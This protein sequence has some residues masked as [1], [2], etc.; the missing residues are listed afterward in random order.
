MSPK[1]SSQ[2]RAAAP[3][4]SSLAAQLPDPPLD[5]LVF[6]TTV[7]QKRFWSL[8]ALQPGNPALNMPLAARL[9]GQVDRRAVQLAFD[10]IARRH[11]VLRCRFE[12]EGDE[13]VQVVLPPRPVEVHWID[14]TSIPA[15]AVAARIEAVQFE[16]GSRSFDLARGPFLRGAVA[17]LDP[18]EH[19]LMLTMHHIVS[20]GWSNGILL[21]EFAG[22]Y[23]RVL[24]GESP[25]FEDLPLQYADFAVWQKGWL[26]GPEG[27]AQK[28]F[29]T[30]HLGDVIPVLNLPTDRPRGRQATIKGTIRSRLLSLELSERFRL[31]CQ[32]ENATPFMGYLTAY[33]MLL[34]RYSGR[35]E[36]VVSSPAACRNQTELEGIIGLFANPIPFRPK[37]DVGM[38][39]R[40]L[41]HHMRDATLANF[42]RQ[43]YPFEILAENLRVE[44][45]RRGVPWLQAYFIFQKAFLQSQHMPGLDL[46]PLRSI[47]PG[48][49][50]EWMLGVVER[51]EGVRLQLEYNTDL[52]DGA[53]IDRALNHLERII[54]TAARTLDFP[55]THLRLDESP[56]APLPALPPLAGSLSDLVTTAFGGN[57]E[58]VLLRCGDRTMRLAELPRGADAA[59]A[60]AAAIARVANTPVSLP[61]AFGLEHLTR[62][63]APLGAALNLTPADRVLSTAPLDSLAGWEEVLAAWLRGASAIRAVSLEAVPFAQAIAGASVVFLPAGHSS[64]LLR[65]QPASL[66]ASLAGVRLVV[67]DQDPVAPAA[68]KAWAAMERRLLG[69]VQPREIGLTVAL[70]EL[71]PTSNPR[72]SFVDIAGWQVDL[73]DRAGV[74]VPYGLPGR[75]RASGGPAAAPPTITGD[76]MRVR[77]DGTLARLGRA[78]DLDPSPGYTLELYE[79]AAT[80]CQH[81]GV[82]SAHAV[83]IATAPGN[84]V[85]LHVVPAAAS[86]VPDDL[87]A[88]LV[89]RLP[90]Y[91]L[92]ATIAVHAHLPETASG[93]IDHTKLHDVRWLT[94]VEVYDDNTGRDEIE[95]RLRDIFADLLHLP[96][97]DLRRSFFD[98]GGHSLLGAKLFARI[99][100]EFQRRLPLATLLTNSS[101]RGLA[102]HLRA[103][104]AE[105]ARWSCL[106]PVQTAGDGPKFFCM[107]GAGGNILL[108]RDLARRMAPAV[109]FYGLQAQ[110]L[111]GQSPCLM[112]I[113]DMA[114]L[115]LREIQAEQPAGPY[116][117]G[118]YCMGGNVAYEIAKLLHRRAEQVNLLAMLDTYNLQKSNFSGN[119]FARFRVWLQKASFH[120]DTLVHLSM[121]Q[122]RVYLSEKLRMAGELLNSQRAA[123]RR[124]FQRT[125]GRDDGNDGLTRFVQSA[126]HVALRAYEPRPFGGQ[127]TLFRPAKNY[128]TFPDPEMGWGELVDG[129]IESV[130]VS[131]NPHAMLIEPFVQQLA[132]ALTRRILNGTAVAGSQ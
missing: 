124:G 90:A 9:V 37:V 31:V 120:L 126:N 73:V 103:S 59:T 15:D 16:E 99:E 92:P 66:A 86:L 55:I 14:C 33:V 122:R 125:A 8:D 118:G 106:V 105:P 60:L 123:S 52:F 112:R 30:E 107:H 11:E 10:E 74:V 25:P 102:I 61:T 82:W 127:L 17:T 96:T 38:T 18:T 83:I 65:Q 12:T 50:F 36:F 58:A 1:A 7:G 78:E 104:A 85:V 100:K 24:R 111:D 42:S 115:Y 76:W 69:R 67:L 98:L 54:A 87:R 93:Q 23:T 75:L 79:I 129:P 3:D 39:F 131:T 91:M 88:F 27:Q 49:I 128:Y 56:D 132:G 32:R 68:L 81:P 117:L 21:R 121:H 51:S 6:P 45:T 46:T 114:A 26:A 109:R 20:D 22:N 89:E 34:H 101:V 13:L 84:H 47:S 94:T 119:A 19:V 110:G 43:E 97:V 44:E 53:T 72:P 4:Q 95:T 64:H 28:N 108:Y 41:L 29:W 77:N 35:H 5:E 57:A 116:Y 80:L 113:E 70:H 40:Q 2:K 48:A 71:L 62:H 63:A 130:V